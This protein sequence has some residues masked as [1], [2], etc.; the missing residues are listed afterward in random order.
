M[1]INKN[2]NSVK[3]YEAI[4]STMK[5][6]V[7]GLRTGRTDLL[8]SVFHKD[9][10][11]HGFWGEHLIEGHIENLYASVEKAGSAPQITSHLTV[12]HKTLTTASVRNEVE[13]NALM[14]NFTEYHS[15]IKI[16]NEWKIVS[17]L[18]HKYDK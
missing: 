18:F 7:E 17:K 9:A 10:I 15:L 13:S 14:E 1:E 6:Y 3:D 4:I 8:R 11:M 2:S 16:N 5:T 12:L